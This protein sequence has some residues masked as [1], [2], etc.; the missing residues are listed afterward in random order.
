MMNVRSV[1][2]RRQKSILLLVAAGMAL[3]LFL[4]SSS[5]HVRY[6]E[7]NEEA[8]LHRGICY[9]SPTKSSI[10][11]AAE[12]M[13]R[14]IELFQDVTFGNISSSMQFLG[15]DQ[16]TK[17]ETPWQPEVPEVPVIVTAAS[18]NHYYE[19]VALCNNI[20]TDLRELYGNITFIIYDLGLGSSKDRAALEKYCGC[21]IRP[22]PFDSFPVHVANVQGYTWKPLVIS[23]MLKEFP[24]VM[25]VDTSV[26][27]NASK[28]IQN[29]LQMA[30]ICHIQQLTEPD[31]ALAETCDIKTMQFLNQNIYDYL[32]ASDVEAGWGVYVRSQF[33]IKRIMEPWVR[34]ALTYG[35]MLTDTYSFA[36]GCN[37]GP[38][39]VVSLCH[40]FEQSVMGIILHKLYG[41]TI[42]NV[43]F[44]E[45]V[46]GEIRRGHSMTFPSM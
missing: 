44:G 30:Q 22:F 27:F 46:Y 43:L 36:T 19:A 5:T 34:C 14:D 33:L 24:F 23:L 15:F 9:V 10:L 40:R 11:S 39:K 7:I 18:Q 6:F 45:S 20:N 16:Y 38:T 32:N 1:L 12:C 29:L 25:W 35:C 3:I 4:S 2:S 26:R 41:G 31:W 42:Q 13:P 28:H 8:K 37:K 21:Q 17:C